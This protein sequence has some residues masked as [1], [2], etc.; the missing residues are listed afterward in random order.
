MAGSTPGPG[1]FRLISFDL[2]GTL[3]D[4]AGEIAEAANRTLA[5]LGLPREDASAITHMIGN[6]AHALM[7]GLLARVLARMAGP[8]PGPPAD[9]VLQAFDAHYEATTGTTS[10][11]Y[12]GV[13]CALADLQHA[14]LRLACVTNKEIRH[15]RRLL[16]HHRLDGFFELTLGGDSLPEKKPHPS[17]LRHAMAQ[18]G[19]APHTTAHV[20]DSSIDIAAARQAGVQAWVVP[21]GYNAGVPIAQCEPDRVFANLLQLRDHLLSPP[22]RQVAGSLSAAP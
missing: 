9:Q 10:T 5:Q 6:G 19:A 1:P 18:L 7:L 13:A 14:G 16:A 11:V 12:E 15:A 22:A 17:V 4:T 20:G 21:Y 3:V 8:T 2:D